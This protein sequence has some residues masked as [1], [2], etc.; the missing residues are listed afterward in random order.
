LLWG[1]FLW[2][3]E[4]LAVMHAGFAPYDYLNALDVGLLIGDASIY[5]RYLKAGKKV[6]A[7]I[8]KNVCNGT[9]MWSNFDRR[10]PKIGVSCKVQ[11]RPPADIFLK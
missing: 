6:K 3:P 1:L 5:F 7:E 2:L 11:R 10:D 4:V 9:V 8:R